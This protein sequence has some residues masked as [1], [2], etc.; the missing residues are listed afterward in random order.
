MKNNTKNIRNGITAILFAMV[1]IASVLAVTA[2]SVSAETSKEEMPGESDIYQGGNNLMDLDIGERYST[3]WKY[4]WDGVNWGESCWREEYS[5]WSSGS[6][7]ESSEFTILNYFG[8]SYNDADKTAILKTGNIEVTRTISIP[9]GNDRYFTISYKLKNTGSSTLSDVRFFE[10]VDY[11]VPWT[12]DHS[13]DTGWYDST[14]DFVWIKD[15]DYFQNGF[16]G[17][18]TSSRHGM[19]HYSTELADDHDGNLNGDNSYYGDPAVGLQYNLGSLGPGDTWEISMTFW[20]GEPYSVTPRY[21]L[22]MSTN[23]G[24]T[25]PV[26]GFY[27]EETAVTITA[28]APTPGPGE[29]YVWNGWTGTGPGSYTG[30]ANPASIT[31]N[32][33]ISETA[34]WVL[35]VN[36]PPVADAG[37]DQTVEQTYYQGASVRLDGSGSSDPDGDPLTYSW[38]WPGGSATGVSP[39]VSLPLGT[40]TVTLVVNDGT[41]DSDP[42]T[43]S[44]TVEDTTPPVITCPA[45]ITV[46]QETADGT[47]VPLTATATDICDADPT[48]TSDAPAIF[49]LGTTTVTFTATDDSGNNASCSMT[50]TVVDTTPPSVDAGPDITVEQA[51]AAG[52][53]VTLSATVSDICDASPIVTWSHGPTAVFPLGTTAVTVT[54]A[55]ATGNSASDTVVVNVVDTTPP[56]VDAGPDITVEQ[57]TAAG[58]E[59]TLSAMVSDICDASPTVTWS[60]GPTAVFPLGTTTVTVTAADATGNSASDTVVVNVI[61]TTLP[62]ITC[63][64][65]VTVEQETRDGTK[66]QLTATATDI[67]DTDVEITNNAPAI[68]PL[69]TTIVT[70]TATDDS[71]NRATCTT[72]VTVIDT[73][74]PVITCPA[75][76]TVEQ[77]SADG[78]VVQLTAT[79]TDICDASPTITSDAPAIFPLGTTTVTFTAKD[80][81]GNSASCSMTVT[82]IDTTAP[83]ITVSVTPATGPYY[84]TDTVSITYTIRDICDAS[85]EVDS[86]TIMN[87]GVMTDDITA[88]SP[89]TLSLATYAGNN[90][91]TVTATDACGNTGT[92]TVNID[93]VF[94]MVDDQLF[95]TPEALKVN[96]GVLTAHTDN[97]PAYYDPTTIQTAFC[98]GAEMD[99]LSDT[100]NMKFRRVD[101]DAALA[102]ELI[103][104]HFEITGTFIYNGATCDFMGSDDIKKIVT[105]D[106]GGKKGKGK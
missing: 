97:W 84:T 52:T 80:D 29:E 4:K 62:V 67:C 21:Y 53:E 7:H 89:I 10:Q 72:T 86:I 61:D 81:S 74:S 69:G 22:T 76:I 82:V 57:A 44:I 6:I 90:V 58:T 16:T 15:P 48:I 12:G 32:G 38:T 63:P 83:A 60:H 33:A 55:D 92:A 101:V 45:D 17:S 50:V 24:T 2:T 78:T 59:V 5:I 43:V 98:D 79:A 19:A 36:N 106:G 37:T 96:P 27:D 11:D 71:R 99:F 104:T 14:N 100:G 77:E 54:A 23:Y 95:I 3:L 85:P 103:D 8:T 41:V 20:F 42:D 9:S 46:E 73:T 64:A 66:V 34:S 26:S 93:V 1:M 39:A 31:M 102:P 18:K 35:I 94:K 68:F 56:T 88:D 70:F 105:D 49:P 47:V 40:T 87:N 75:D 65:D 28:I 51:T 30:M 13:D 25:I 91:V